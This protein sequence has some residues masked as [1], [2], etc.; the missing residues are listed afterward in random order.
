MNRVKLVTTTELA[1]LFKV[2]RQTV[3]NWR[4]DGCPV[5]FSNKKTIRYDFHAVIDWLRDKD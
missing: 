2:T 4:K 5:Y 3:Y 1:N